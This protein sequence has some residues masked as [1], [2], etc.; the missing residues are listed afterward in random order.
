MTIVAETADVTV[1][2][3]TPEDVAQIV[4]MIHA[5]AH[6]EGHDE[7][8]QATVHSISRLLF[9][10]SF[11]LR[12]N[13]PTGKPAV[14]ALVVDDPAGSDLLLGM[15]IWYVNVSTWEARYGIHLED[16]F[17][18]T[19]A[20]GLGVGKALVMTLAALADENDYAR[21][22]WAVRDSNEHARAFYRSLQAEEMEEW[23]TNRLSGRDLQRL[24][25][26]VEL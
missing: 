25:D 21:V 26:E 24:A 18:R 22:E 1:R 2:E 13:T 12:A 4:D 5:L 15:A 8:V 3:A 16:L 23:L 19:E 7:S 17:V 9:P 10:E 6:N 20:R 11:G 14:F